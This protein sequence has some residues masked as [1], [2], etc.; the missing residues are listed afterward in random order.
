MFKATITFND[1]SQAVVDSPQEF[2]R[3]FF[4][5][6]KRAFNVRDYC[7]IASIVFGGMIADNDI[8]QIGR[9][10]KDNTDILNIEFNCYQVKRQH[11][12]VRMFALSKEALK[13]F[14]SMA[15]IH[16]DSVNAGTTYYTNGFIWEVSRASIIV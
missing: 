11:Q 15:G 13:D 6:F 4:E 16:S 5:R 3:L 10:L 2:T 9:V 8:E 14:L 7:K 12:D 1:Q